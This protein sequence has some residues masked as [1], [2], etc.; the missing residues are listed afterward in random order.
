MKA[1]LALLLTVAVFSTQLTAADASSEVSAKSEV[2]SVQVGGAVHKYGKYEFKKGSTVSDAIASA[3][4][5]LRTAIRNKVQLTRMEKDG[6]L[7][8]YTLD[9]SRQGRPEDNMTLLE[10]DNVFVPEVVF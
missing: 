3:G 9:L 10:N 2:I 6:K 1:T 5:P 7:R 4:G 8:V